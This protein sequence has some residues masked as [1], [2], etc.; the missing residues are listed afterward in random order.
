MR[1]PRVRFIIPPDLV[2]TKGW[3]ALREDLLVDGMGRAEQR[4][5]LA[6]RFESLQVWF[7]DLDDFDSRSPA[8]ILA[9]RAVGAGR[10]SPAYIKWALRTL[11]LF[12]RYGRKRGGPMSWKLYYDEFLKADPEHDWLK[13]EAFAYIDRMLTPAGVAGLLYPS[14]QEFYARFGADKY[15]MTRSLERI[16]YRYSKVIPYAGCYHEVRDKALVVADFIDEHP[17]IRNYGSGG[18]SAEDEEVAKTLES[19]YRKGEIEKP[20]CLF[21]ASSPLA[22]NRA[23]NVFVGKDR[24]GLVDVLAEGQR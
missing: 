1:G 7:S 11:L 4:K 8:K 6:R 15:L 2:G 16:A 23:F 9:M 14:V 18:D 13:D 17:Y 21:R 19:L 12:C 3:L 20:L 10:I 24:S 5:D 22:L